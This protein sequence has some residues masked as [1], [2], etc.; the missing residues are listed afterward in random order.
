MGSWSAGTIHR[1]AGESSE[2]ST[3]L[4]RRELRVAGQVVGQSDPRQAFGVPIVQRRRDL[5]RVIDAADRDVD[6]SR[7]LAGGEADLRAADRAEAPPGLGR[8][9]VGV[10]LPLR[11]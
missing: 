5:F 8:G 1:R 4:D 10:G 3:S 7:N 2:P 6:Q 11:T 9:R